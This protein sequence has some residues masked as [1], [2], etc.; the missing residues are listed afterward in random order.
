[1]IVAIALSFPCKAD[2]LP[3]SAAHTDDM[4]LFRELMKKPRKN[5]RDRRVK[6]ERYSIW[7]VIIQLMN[8]A[9]TTA[10]KAIGER[11]PYK[12]SLA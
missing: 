4:M 8:V 5:I 11:T 12:R 1:M 2:Y 3:R 7:N 9:H 10:I 6:S